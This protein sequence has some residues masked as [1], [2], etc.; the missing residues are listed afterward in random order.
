V[1]GAEIVLA[2]LERESRSQG[3]AYRL[4]FA[5]PPTSLESTVKYPRIDSLV[6]TVI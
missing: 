3:R 4:V 5:V 6:T 1:T 2:F